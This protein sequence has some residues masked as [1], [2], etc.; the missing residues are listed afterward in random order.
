[1]QNAKKAKSNG[2]FIK[3]MT[4]KE[5]IRIIKEECYIF[6]ML[7]FDRTTLVNTALDKAIAAL[8]ELDYIERTRK[9]V[10]HEL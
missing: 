4:N 3:Q 7:N 6:N 9:G 5:A 1:M 2:E 8:E 10:K